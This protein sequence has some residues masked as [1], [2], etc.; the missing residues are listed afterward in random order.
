MLENV[1]YNVNTLE[2]WWSTA[3]LRFGTILMHALASGLVGLG[4]YYALRRHQRGRLLGLGLA[5]V[6]LHGLWN[7]S[8][9]VIIKLA[10]DQAGNADPLALIAAG[11]GVG[12]AMLAW[13]VG[14]TLGTVLLLIT[15]PHRLAQATIQAHARAMTSPALAT[16]AFPVRA[17]YGR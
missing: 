1:F 2:D 13:N 15:I 14:L 5:A 4:W 6:A 3:A 11:N 12:W 16:G 10:V 8:Q 9:I 7:A 17:D